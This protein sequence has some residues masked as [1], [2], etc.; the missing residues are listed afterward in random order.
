MIKMKLL[1]I[2]VELNGPEEA[3]NWNAFIGNIWNSIFE[4]YKLDKQGKLIEIA[5]GSVN[6]VGNGLTKY[7]FE[8]NLFVVEP[9]LKSLVEIS[10]KYKEDLN[11]K[12]NPISLSLRDSIPILP[13]KTNAIVANHPLDDMII[14]KFL[15][16][17][18]FDDLFDD[19]YKDPL[20][21]NTRGLWEQLEKYP[22]LLEK[23]KQE[24]VGEWVALINQTNPDL[25]VISQYDSY[26]FQSNGIT[27]PD[28]HAFDILNKL[29]GI[30]KDSVREIN[31]EENIQD[32]RKWL[33]LEKPKM[34]KFKSKNPSKK[35]EV[36]STSEANSGKN[37]QRNK[38]K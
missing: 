4:Y 2:N 24:I 36:K 3:S 34:H 13:I 9:N 37:K 22:N 1:T 33:V 10:D 30:Y 16:K 28:K 7:G 12:V 15:S 19:H 20:S 38:V 21:N 25:V 14:G 23:Y 32:S 18:A 31:F 26:F 27:S 5:P 11:A 35:L 29:K 6:K 8:G 17:E